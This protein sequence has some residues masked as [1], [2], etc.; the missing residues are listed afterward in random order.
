M[1]LNRFIQMYAQRAR[2]SVMLPAIAALAGLA[3]ATDTSRLFQ[4]S[5]APVWTLV[6]LASGAVSSLFGVL[7]LLL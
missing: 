4:E 6:G 5:S 2:A 1:L 3:T 7:G